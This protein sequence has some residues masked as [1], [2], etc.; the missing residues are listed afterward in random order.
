MLDMTKI[1]DFNYQKNKAIDEDREA[2]RRDYSNLGFIGQK[3][4]IRINSM[5]R[6]IT[7]NIERESG[8]TYIPP[9][10]FSILS[11]Y[12]YN[13]K[14]ILFDIN[15]IRDF[16]LDSNPTP[17]EVAFYNK[18]KEALLK[19]KDLLDRKRALTSTEEESKII[20][21]S[22]IRDRDEIRRTNQEKNTLYGFVREM[23]YD[24]VRKYSTTGITRLITLLNRLT[25]EE[26]PFE[27]YKAL[28]REVHDP[29]YVQDILRWAAMYNP[30]AQVILDK[31]AD[32]RNRAYYGEAPNM[33]EIMTQ[34]IIKLL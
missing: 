5:I 15:R 30:K 13:Q 16:K 31:L 25:K 26:D 18:Y 1:N 28:K 11:N 33:E 22:S 17:L 8:W 27:A 6:T 21:I 4:L 2:L 12:R 9:S 7:F 3:R 32:E 20:D 34:N 10:T 14:E 23:A 24:F 19:L 29:E